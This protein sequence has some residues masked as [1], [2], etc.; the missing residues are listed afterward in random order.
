MGDIINFIVGSAVFCIVLS[1]VTP[2]F[3]ALKI[4]IKELSR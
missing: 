2:F 4:I 1:A 3:M